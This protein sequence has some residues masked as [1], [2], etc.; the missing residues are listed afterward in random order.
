MR[1]QYKDFKEIKDEL[2]NDFMEENQE[3]INNMNDE[4]FKDLKQEF[5]ND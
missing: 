4:D 2:L 5:I 3:Q 1:T